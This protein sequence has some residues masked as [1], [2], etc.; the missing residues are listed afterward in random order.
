LDRDGTERGGQKGGKKSDESNRA[1]HDPQSPS[2][3]LLFSAS[4]LNRG[5]GYLATIGK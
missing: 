2:S 4:V 1:A 5:K 3:V